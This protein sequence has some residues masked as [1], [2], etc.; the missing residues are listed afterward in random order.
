MSYNLYQSN[1]NMQL[2]KALGN[3]HALINLKWPNIT[4]WKALIKEIYMF[5]H[6]T[7]TQFYN[8]F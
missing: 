1:V 6:Q 8:T 7:E 5:S 2:P 3:A 4:I